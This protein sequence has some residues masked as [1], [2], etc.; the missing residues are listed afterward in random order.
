MQAI[1][2]TISYD[3][4]R[5][6]GW[7]VQDNALT[8]Q[9]C[10]M[11][12]GRSFLKDDFTITTASRTDAG[13][14]ALGQRAL[15]KTESTMPPNKI[16][17]AFNHYLPKDIQI[18]KAEMVPQD[19]H[20]R[21]DAKRKIYVYK[22][23]N[24]TVEMPLMA[25]DHYLFERETDFQKMQ[26]IAGK[27]VGEHDFN[28]FSAKK[29][30]VKDTVRRVI[31][32]EVKEV[33]QEHVG[34]EAGKAYYIYIEGNGFLYNMVRIIAGC[35]LDWGSA[36]MSEEEIDRQ[37]EAAFQTGE[38]EFAARTLPAKGLTLLEIFYGSN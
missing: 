25:K 33:L 10:M 17:H 19:F 34:P 6:A 14:H 28:A 1:L 29:K 7:Q 9:E 11:K 38:R 18:W 20:P 24:G 22:I 36:K 27:F 26:Y 30:S 37:M 15:L 35:I 21:Y 3:G 32:C 13:V 12:A 23:W 16:K 2:F 4:S 5:Y 31:R 8:I